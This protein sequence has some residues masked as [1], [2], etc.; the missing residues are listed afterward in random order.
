M[1]V[2][3]VA[4]AAVLASVLVG[5]VDLQAKS[6][7]G[8]DQQT[9]GC[10]SGTITGGGVDLNGYQDYG[11]SSAGSSSSDDPESDWSGSSDTVATDDSGGRKRNLAPLI[12]PCFECTATAP[13]RISDLASFHPAAPSTSPEPNGW[14]VVALDVNFVANAPTQ[15]L[16]G[17][18]LGH[19]AQVRFMPVGY[20]WSFGDGA[21]LETSTPGSSWA[22]L[23]VDEFTPTA[24]SHRYDDRGTYQVRLVVTY[25]A[26]YRLGGQ[27][28]NDIVGTLP[29]SAEPRSL[30]IGDAKTVLV[31]RD[32]ATDPSGPGC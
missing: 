22:A 13:V 3:V 12:L 21:T 31:D 29:L 18:L 28:W 10:T 32:C 15:T 11:G 6:C 7:T 23:G 20:S 1:L 16:D 25:R 9:G 14:G 19:P 27:A 17:V 30:T 8:F 26:E 4:Y 5:S 24:T 2:N